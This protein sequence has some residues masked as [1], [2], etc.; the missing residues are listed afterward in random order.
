[1]LLKRAESHLHRAEHG[2]RKHVRRLDERDGARMCEARISQRPKAVR[3]EP[4]PVATC[5][6]TAH[7]TDHRIGDALEEILLAADV[8]V[9][10]HRRHTEVF[11]E[12]PN[13][14]AG[15]THPIEKRDCFLQH[16]TATE[17]VGHD[18]PRTIRFLSRRAG[19]GRVRSSAVGTWRH[20]R[21]IYTVY[22][23]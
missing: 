14:E 13:A 10:G 22:I 23:E 17:R 18:R 6:R 3:D 16:A 12:R 4:A 21:R 9:H 19:S 5:R 20:V 15:W 11:R 8:V 2:Y 1:G 7:L